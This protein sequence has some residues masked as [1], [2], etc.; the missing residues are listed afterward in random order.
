MELTIQEMM[1]VA[2]ARDKTDR[3]KANME[4]TWDL[5]LEMHEREGWRV[6]GY[7]NWREYGMAEFD[8]SKSEIYRLADAAKIKHNISPMGEKSISERQLRP[9]TKLPADLQR[10]AW[11]IA[12]ETAPEGKVTARH[13]AKTVKE[14]TK[15]PETPKPESTCD[16]IW[17]EKFKTELAEFDAARR[18]MR[19]VLYAVKRESES[20]DWHTEIK[21]VFLK[22]VQQLLDIT[23]T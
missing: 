13:V 21:Q 15:A 8:R 12:V 18:A 10:E 5:L 4:E 7:P 9:L 19:R 1:S 14:L 22:G 20:E 3:I 17:Q 16:I 23:L 6:L 2:E 11:Q